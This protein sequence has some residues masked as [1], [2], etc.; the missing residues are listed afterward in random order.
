MTLLAWTL[1]ESLSSLF[2]KDSEA[3]KCQTGNGESPNPPWN[4]LG[5][6]GAVTLSWFNAFRK[7]VAMGGKITLLLV[8]SS[9]PGV[10]EEYHK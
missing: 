5:N 9:A 7:V 10:K 2:L 3:I 4:S 6:F 8:P 1:P